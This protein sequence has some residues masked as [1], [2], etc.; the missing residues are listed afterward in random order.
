VPR[1]GPAASRQLDQT[2]KPTFAVIAES[3][4]GTNSGLLAITMTGGPAVIEVDVEW[5]AFSRN[6][7]G[8]EVGTHDGSSE[9]AIKIV[10]NDTIEYTFDVP[11][12]ARSAACLS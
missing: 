9:V 5:T 6:E 4:A 2:D 12:S 7:A 10:R 1:P 8:Q 3:Q 11:R